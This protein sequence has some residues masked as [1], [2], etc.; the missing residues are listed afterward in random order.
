[1]YDTYA[2]QGE[3]KEDVH[4]EEKGE[5]GEERM[6]EMM[7]A[8]S[9]TSLHCVLGDGGGNALTVALKALSCVCVLVSVFI[10]FIGCYWTRYIRCYTGTC[11][12]LVV[13]TPQRSML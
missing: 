10:L 7:Y 6:L 4:E 11:A 3:G 1:M 9:P 12:V 2:E 13:P 8:K 5:R